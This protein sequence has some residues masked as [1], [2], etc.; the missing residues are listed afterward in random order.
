MLS[1]GLQWVGDGDGVCRI[2]FGDEAANQTVGHIAATDKRQCGF[3]HR[4]FL[5]R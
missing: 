4:C 3:V 2:A 5:K 1:I